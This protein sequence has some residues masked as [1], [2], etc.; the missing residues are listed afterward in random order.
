[1]IYCSLESRAE[2]G[3]WLQG[4]EAY[5]GPGSFTIQRLG[6]DHVNGSY[7]LWCALPAGGTLNTI[8]IVEQD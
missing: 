2:D 1:V 3:T 4:Y 8:R 5:S 6:F 7:S